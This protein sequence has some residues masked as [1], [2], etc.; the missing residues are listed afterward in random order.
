MNSPQGEA[1]LF[2]QRNAY[3]SVGAVLAI[4]F[5]ESVTVRREPGS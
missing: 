3:G 1:G 2:S 5:R 4:G